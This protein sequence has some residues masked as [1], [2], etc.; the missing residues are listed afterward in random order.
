MRKPWYSTWN[1]QLRDRTTERGPLRMPVLGV[2]TDNSTA[3]N[4]TTFS[5]RTGKSYLF[6]QYAPVHL[7]DRKSKYSSHQQVF[8]VSFHLCISEINFK[9][10]TIEWKLKCWSPNVHEKFPDVTMERQRVSSSRGSD[11]AH[12]SCGHL[13]P[14]AQ[15]W[16]VETFVGGSIA[17]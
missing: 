7:F 10:I 2:T 4:S 13:L 3:Q 12:I 16:Q 9:S 8:L 17:P 15:E 14:E 11:P 5:Q 1:T 6:L